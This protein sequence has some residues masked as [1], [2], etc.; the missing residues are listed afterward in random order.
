M[1]KLKDIIFNLTGIDWKVR[2]SYKDAGGKGF[3]QRF[4]ETLAEEYDDYTNPL[5]LDLVDNCLVPH[6]MYTRFIPYQEQQLGIPYITS[7]E[8]IRR[9][10]LKYIFKV[11]SI[12]STKISY[13]LMFRL[14]GFEVDFYIS[15][16]GDLNIYNLYIVES[17][18]ETGSVVVDDGSGPQTLEWGDKFYVRNNT[19]TVTTFNGDA[20]LRR[21]TVVD[22][23]GGKTGFDATT[24]YE[25]VKFDDP[26]RRFDQKCRTCSPYVIR[27]FGDLPLTEE[28]HNSIFRT[29]EL[30]EPINAQLAAVFYNDVILLADDSISIWIDQDPESE[31]YGDL[32]YDNTSVSEETLTINS[33]GDL[34]INGVP[35]GKYSIDSMGDMYVNN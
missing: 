18:S 24:P 5:I 23:F 26:S 6:L 29:I 20:V 7:Q 22:I 14:L 31:T 34:I 25:N 32:F 3:I 19:T 11:Y 27:L 10:L 4:L 33:N 17:L 9:K 30:L 2:D 12:K 35:I 21:E 28:L 16:A 13:E 1:W 8:S 15:S